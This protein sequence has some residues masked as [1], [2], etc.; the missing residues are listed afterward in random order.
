MMRLL[1]LIAMGIGYFMLIVWALLLAAYLIYRMYCAHAARLRRWREAS[2]RRDPDPIECHMPQLL[3]HP[4]PRI[5]R[6]PIERAVGRVETV[7]QLIEAA[8]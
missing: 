6:A 1:D 3:R 2:A 7:E 4:R 8:R 5:A